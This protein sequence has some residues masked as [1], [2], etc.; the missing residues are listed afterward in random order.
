VSL[1]VSVAIVWSL[2]VV[3]GADLPQHLAC[4]RIFADLSSPAYP[5]RDFFAAPARLQPYDTVYLL[6]AAVARASS[7]DTASRLLATGYAGLTFV[8]FQSLTEALHGRHETARP[9]TP[10]FATLLVWSPVVMMGFLQFYL[11][12]PLILLA[13]ARLVSAQ[14]SAAPARDLLRVAAIGGVVACIHPAAAGALVLIAVAYA[15]VDSGDGAPRRRRMAGLLAG[16]CVATIAIWHLRGEIVGGEMGPVDW[17]GAVRDAQG[18]EFVNQVLGITWYDPPVTANYVAWTVLGPY[19]VAGL[20]PQIV[21]AAWIAVVVV[22][23]RGSNAF[24]P[25][26]RLHARAC[27]AFAAVALLLPWGI[28]AP[29][30]LTFINFRFIGVA[31]AIALP[32]LPPAAFAA[33]GARHAILGWTAVTLVNL[34]LNMALFAREA[35]EPLALVA[36]VDPHGVLLPVVFRGT[37]LRF[38]KAF[39]VT[40]HVPTLFTAERGGITTQFWAR[41]TRHLPFDYLPGK[42]PAQPPDWNPERFDP[43]QHLRDVDWVLLEQADADVGPARRADSD[44]VRRDLDSHAEIVA[45]RGLWSLYRVHHDALP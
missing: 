7:I 38:A 34:A 37:S 5:F 11:C 17:R 36:R 6:L 15:V 28:A 20:V 33:S 32:L 35:R 27:V 23:K 13:L 12:V 10:V 18:V 43:D 1:A 25:R 24:D 16:A 22:R 44:R 19:R 41:Y 42:R 45:T 21:V 2:P 31:F 39:R 30:E 40:H 14:E 9:V 3:P 26:V 4:A 8:A 29:E